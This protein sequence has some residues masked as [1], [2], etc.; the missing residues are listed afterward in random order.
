MFIGTLYFALGEKEK[1]IST[2]RVNEDFGHEKQ[3]SPII[4]RQMES[5]SLK[6][7]ELA[8]ELKVAL[9]STTI[10]PIEML[11]KISVGNKGIESSRRSFKTLYASEW[12][13]ANMNSILTSVINT[14]VENHKNSLRWYVPNLYELDKEKVQEE[15]FE[16]FTLFYDSFLKK[17]QNKYYTALQ[18]DLREK[19]AKD[20]VVIQRINYPI[21]QKVQ[22]VKEA[23]K[24]LGSSWWEWLLKPVF[25]IWW[26]IKTIFFFIVKVIGFI[27]VVIINFFASIYNFFSGN[28]DITEMRNELLKE[29][30]VIY[31]TELPNAYWKNIQPYIIE[32]IRTSEKEI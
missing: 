12:K 16:R 8:A 29:N 13:D 30:R 32:S 25:F 24:Y 7:V 5:G 21:V 20:F 27:V 14:A 17:F 9:L 19:G 1:G 15:I 10:I 31:T 23:E 22:P 26:L 4:L 11:E 28:D 6:L 2:V 18:T 3:I